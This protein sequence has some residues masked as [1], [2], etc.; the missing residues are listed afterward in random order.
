MVL[1][2]SWLGGWRSRY[3]AAVQGKGTVRR[4]LNLMNL[5]FLDCKMMV[6]YVDGCLYRCNAWDMGISETGL[7]TSMG[8]ATFTQS[9]IVIDTSRR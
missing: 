8:R 4:G 2:G 5:T 6:L 9:M 1:G 7:S 3:S